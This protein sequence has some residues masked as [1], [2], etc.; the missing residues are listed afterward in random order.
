ML[1]IKDV[2]EALEQYAPLENQADY[3]N[4]GLLYGDINWDYKGALIT[5]DTSVDTDAADEEED[6]TFTTTVPTVEE[7]DGELVDDFD[8][9]EDYED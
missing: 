9:V 3:D 4:S 5:L 8:D 6:E 7:A 1:K 2:I